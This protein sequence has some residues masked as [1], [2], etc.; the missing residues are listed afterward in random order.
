MISLTTFFS[1]VKLPTISEVAHAL[2]ATLDDE[3]ASAKKVAAIIARDPALT[4][5][6]MRLA[7]SARFGAR[8]G[9]SSLDEAIG[10]T[11]MAHIR[12]LAL[13]TC[14]SDAFPSLPTSSGRAARPAPAM[15]NGWRAASASTAAKRGWPA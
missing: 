1:D 10:L 4:A 15:P 13:A 14:F 7:N 12:T 2:I 5:K 11:G 3:D 9:V 8:R 6:L